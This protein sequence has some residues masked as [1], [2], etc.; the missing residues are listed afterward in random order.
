MNQSVIPPI[1]QLLKPAVEAL[2]SKVD[3]VTLGPSDL[4]GIRIESDLHDGLEFYIRDA[5]GKRY[6]VSKLALKFL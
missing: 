6:W 4:I 3:H 5:K 2:P 1:I